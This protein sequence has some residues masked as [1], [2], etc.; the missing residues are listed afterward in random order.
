MCSTLYFVQLVSVSRAGVTGG[1]GQLAFWHV[2]DMSARGVNRALGTQ[3]QILAGGAM[4]NMSVGQHK[5]VNVTEHTHSRL[6]HA[7][8]HNVS[9]LNK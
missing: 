3:T 9:F 1:G 2:L 7:H 6:L 8:F 5:Y 4:W